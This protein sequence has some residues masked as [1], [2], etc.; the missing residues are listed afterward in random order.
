M[1][2]VEALTIF[3]KK[4]RCENC[5]GGCLGVAMGSIKNAIAAQ[6]VSSY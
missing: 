1:R 4:S 2:G 3:F 6:R 5:V